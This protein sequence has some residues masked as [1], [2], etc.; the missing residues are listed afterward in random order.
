MSVDIPT[1]RDY[2]ADERAK[3]A[4]KERAKLRRQKRARQKP[5][6]THYWTDQQRATL[7][8]MIQSGCSYK[9]VAAAIGRPYRGVQCE[10][11]S[12]GLRYKGR[13][14]WI[15]EEDDYLREWYY[16]KPVKVIAAKLGR[17][18]DD[19]NYRRRFLGMAAKAPR[20]KDNA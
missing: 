20:G 11:L 13:N 5:Q 4:R 12:M 14:Y 17:K 9:E 3:Q 6:S 18:E 7:R 1:L 2:H 8:E 19:I 15:P 16:K 10:A